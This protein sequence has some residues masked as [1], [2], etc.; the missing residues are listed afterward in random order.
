MC[1]FCV[2]YGILC[3]LVDL[4]KYTVMKDEIIREIK[5]SMQTVI[6]AEQMS[7]LSNVLIRTLQHV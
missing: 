3:I 1:Y 7:V 5:A 6:S 2:D 4:I